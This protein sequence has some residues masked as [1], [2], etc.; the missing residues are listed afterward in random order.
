MFDINNVPI[1]LS[2]D[3]TRQEQLSLLDNI[4]ETKLCLHKIMHVMHLAEALCK[5]LPWVWVE[6]RAGLFFSV[7]GT[8]SE[9]M[10][11]QLL[12]LAFLGSLDITLFAYFHIMESQ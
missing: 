4:L 11:I 6:R 10:K 5:S 7:P 9:P 2:F 3:N 8:S 12:L 1:Y